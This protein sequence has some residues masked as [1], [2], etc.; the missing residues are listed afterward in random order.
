MSR[1]L[2]TS[3]R[4]QHCSSQTHPL[5]STQLD[6][7]TANCCT[8]KWPFTLYIPYSCALQLCRGDNEW[9]TLANNL[10]LNRLFQHLPY[11]R[12]LNNSQLIYYDPRRILRGFTSDA[13][14]KR[15][16]L[17]Q[18]PQQCNWVVQQFKFY[19]HPLY[20]K[21]FIWSLFSPVPELINHC[22]YVCVCVCS[23]GEA[24]WIKTPSLLNQYL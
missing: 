12:T 23:S 3:A 5:Q 17:P 7:Y 18:Q 15:L 16:K 2:E 1:S 24:E 22:W 8:S 9:S 6:N 10:C 21:K 13:T 20:C 4:V 11:S 19:M 14:S